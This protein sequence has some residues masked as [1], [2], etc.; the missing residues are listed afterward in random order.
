MRFSVHRV[1]SEAQS[2]LPSRPQLP[3]IRTYSG[4][5]SPSP[6]AD[7]L[8]TQAPAEPPPAPQTARAERP[9]R[10]D[11]ADQP[12]PA[13]DRNVD[14]KPANDN[15]DRTDAQDAQDTKDSKD[16][17]A[18]TDGS[19]D[20]KSAKDAKKDAKDGKAAGATKDG[21]GAKAA[22]AAGDK[23]KSD[24]QTAA[25]DAMFVDATTP[26][27]IVPQATTV[28][29]IQP[30][31]LAATTPEAGTPEAD[32]LAA[33]QAA[34]GQGPRGTPDA[35][36]PG[37]TQAGD[38]TTDASGKSA[39]TAAK[40]ATT[41]GPQTAVPEVEAGKDGETHGSGK[42][43]KALGEFHRAAAELLAKAD[44]HASAQASSDTAGAVKAS[45]D[46]VQN[47]GVAAPANATNPTTTAATAPVAAQVN[48][49]GAAAVPVPLS[50]LAVEIT[51]Q[52][53][54]G[55]NH[56]EIRLDP[57]DLGRIN[58]KLDVDSQGNVTTHLVVDRADTLDLLKR[59]ASSLE[60]ALQQ[61]GLKTSDTALDFSL[62]QHSF[63]Q[64]DDTP[65]QTGAQQVIVPDDDPAP[66]EALRQGY[67]RLL[68]L[69][70]G[71]DIRI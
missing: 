22:G 34:A 15:A 50:G 37:Q 28:A 14:A 10:P 33:L 64:N 16:A 67:G 52:A 43:D 30:L 66:L 4:A 65:A 9:D 70:R 17:K 48:A 39:A 38:K 7:L 40:G 23:A 69:G 31:T 44:V 12:K 26:A 51:T 61:A 46:A 49:Q 36:K 59:D 53:Q 3:A 5:D 45:A 27:V 56:F 55:R 41:A 25:L 20:T 42:D 60:R 57:P 71:L 58:V 68:G 11:R 19:G 21:K 13:D 54:A 63:A 18:A 2:V 47:L 32:A 62:R 8:D 29:A 1:A 35:I 24:D 6:F